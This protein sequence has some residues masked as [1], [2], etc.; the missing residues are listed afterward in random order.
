MSEASQTSLNLTRRAILAYQA[1]HPETARELL[2]EAIQ[3]DPQNELAWLWLAALAHTNHDKRYCLERALEINPKGPARDA[4][5]A[6]GDVTPTVPT[7]VAGAD[8]LPRPDEIMFILAMGTGP[9]VHDRA[10]GL[11][12][13]EIKG[14]DGQR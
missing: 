10:G 2:A 12:A 11:K 14:E 3:D 6:L 5:V 9:R 4:L 1:G 13:S 8:Q 7:Y